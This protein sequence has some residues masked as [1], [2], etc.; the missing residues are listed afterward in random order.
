MQAQATIAAVCPECGTRLAGGFSRGLGRCMIC[1]LRVGF[2]DAEEPNDAPLSS[3]TDRLGNYRIEHRDDGTAWELGHGAMGVTYRAI[4]TS[5]QRPVALKLIASEWVKRG[6]EARERF[7]REARTAASLR[8]P[9]VA[10]VYHFG[11][12]EE[13]GQC[14]CAMELVEGETLETYVRRTGPLDALTTI[15]IGLQVSGALAAAEKQGLVHRDL[16]P[17]NLMLVAADSDAETSNRRQAEAPGIVVKVIDFGVAKALV[18]K[19]DAMGLTHGGFVGT[20]AFASPEQFTDAPVDVRS[21]IYS[22]GATLWYLLTGH[23]PFEGATIEQICASQRSRLLSIEQLKAARVPSRLI[24]LLVSMLAREPAAR[25]SIRALTLQLQDCRAQI[26]DRWRAARRLAF[27]AGLIGIV[28]AAFALFPRWHNR[29]TSH[30][31]APA[32]IPE[33]SIAILPFEN[34]SEDKENAF[35]ADGMQDDVLTSLVQVKDLKVIGRSSVM[36]YRDAANRNLREIGRQLNV[37][38][39]LEGSVQRIANRL[40]VYVNLIDT[41]DGRSLWAERYDR[42]IADS[43]GLQGELAADVAGALRATLGPGEKARL[44]AGTTRNP[45]AYVL[46]LRGREYQM[47]PEVSQDNYLAAENFYKQAVTLDP[48]FA[49]ARA[50]LAEMQL[51]LYQRFFMSRPARLAEARSTA[52]EALRL[53]PD[54]GQAHMVLAGCMM[55]AGD[56]TAAMRREVAAA[57]SL[58]PNDAYI[59][60]AVA[61]LQKDMGWNDEA[62][63]SFERAMVL[64]PREGKVFYNYSTLFAE[65]DVPD[66]P[67]A[68]WAS[69]RA[70]ELSPDSVYFRLMR[71][72]CEFEW[73]GE[74]ARGKA[75]LA[76]LPAGKDPDGR[77][78]TAHCTIALYERDFS[79]ALRLLAA[80]QL[81]RIPFVDGSFGFGWMVPKAYVEGMVHFWAGHLQEAYASLDSARWMLEIEAQESEAQESA[82]RWWTNTT[83]QAEAHYHLAS[84]Y[85][86]MGWTDAAK[87]AIARSHKKPDPAQMATVFT[88][89]GDHDSALPLLELV[90]SAW[91]PARTFLRWDPRW[92]SL[93]TDPRF[94]KLLSQDSLGSRADTNSR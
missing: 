41:R 10:T 91:R 54:C 37:A 44:Q 67:R 71:A 53:D 6:A 18:E 8:H 87:A 59:A 74:V 47:R 7:M 68:R 82:L 63:A 83:A 46:Y 51:W 24:S 89:L 2:D 39:V 32:N 12:R 90:V 57:V 5:L 14:F 64:N 86:A 38:H 49:L 30:N 55:A 92:D 48:S 9:N 11:I 16:K 1:L 73:T 36:S 79:E 52:E 19:P 70:L 93:R 22:L 28:A 84:A 60:L 4:D 80:C 17:A 66:I 3:V 78:T 21:D 20:P 65:R 29:A 69:D 34:R 25:P 88:L 26:L 72:G 27:V 58:V 35:L 61:M 43:T 56:S 40:L 85:A 62:A 15:E 81:E 13:N 33:K 94:Q 23:R 77:V 31:A 76:G 50:R 45:D 75:V 42:T